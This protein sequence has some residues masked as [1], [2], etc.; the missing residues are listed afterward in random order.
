MSGA[1]EEDKKPA[2]AGIHIN[3]KV[4]GQVRL[5]FS[6]PSPPLL[7]SPSPRIKTALLASRRDHRLVV[8]DWIAR[9][10]IF[11]I[12]RMTLCSAILLG[13]GR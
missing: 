9:V 2:D 13:A 3:L 8:L 10:A 7:S 12:G 11:R 1:G 6:L 5:R 4:K